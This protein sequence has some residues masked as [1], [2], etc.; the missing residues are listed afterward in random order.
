MKKQVRISEKTDE[1]M[2]LDEA[3]IVLEKPGRKKRHTF[4]DSLILG[5]VDKYVKFG[6]FPWKFMIHLVLLLLTAWQVLL[7]ITPQTTYESQLF[8]T[9]N[10]LFLSSDPD[11]LDPPE[12][13]STV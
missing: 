6:I 5:P 7:Q 8:L 9:L 4:K 12:I 3:P 10:Q 13:M 11:S 2:Y 1:A